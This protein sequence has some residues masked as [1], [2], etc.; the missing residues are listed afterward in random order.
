MVVGGVV[1]FLRQETAPLQLPTVMGAMGTTQLND[2]GLTR[3]VD[4][5][6]G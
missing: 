6:H 4:G 2:E 5:E 3:L 1:H